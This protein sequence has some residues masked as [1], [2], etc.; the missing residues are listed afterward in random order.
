MNNLQDKPFY[1]EKEGVGLTEIKYFVDYMMFQRTR[2][3]REPYVD[4]NGVTT[5][6]SHLEYVPLLD[7]EEFPDILF[8]KNSEFTPKEFAGP[9]LPRLNQSRAG[10]SAQDGRYM[11]PLYN[12]KKSIENYYNN[13]LKEG[14]HNDLH[15]F[16]CQLN[17]IFLNNIEVITW[18]DESKRYFNFNNPRCED[19]NY[20]YNNDF[21]NNT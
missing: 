21:E 2:D 1:I 12:I 13:G 10:K 8:T 16:S 4:N 6:T 18:T 14:N 15:Y 7:G 3:I 11:I 19:L 20:Y 9:S 5:Y 17:K